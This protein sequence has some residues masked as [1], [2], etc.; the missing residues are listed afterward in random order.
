M[1]HIIT[2]K[3]KGIHSMHTKHAVGEHPR[4]PLGMHWKHTQWTNKEL[5][6]QQQRS[7]TWYCSNPYIS[8]STLR[9]VDKRRTDTTTASS[10][11][12][13]FQGSCILLTNDCMYVRLNKT[14]NMSFRVRKRADALE[15]NCKSQ[16][17]GSVSI[18]ESKGSLWV[19]T[20]VVTRKTFQRCMSEF[21]QGWSPFFRARISV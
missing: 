13:T 21:S 9:V 3:C 19:C 11:C 4:K 12:V 8:E 10:L 20:R 7:L 6:H 18:T 17:G 2:L 15:N 14:Y 5:K 1:W 16:G